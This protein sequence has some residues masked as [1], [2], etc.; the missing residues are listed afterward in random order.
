MKAKFIIYFASLAFLSLSITS[1]DTNDEEPASELDSYTLLAEEQIDGTSLMAKIYQENDS[2]IVGYNRFEIVLS[3]TGFKGDFT[4]AEIVFKPMMDMGTMQHACPIE[5]PVAGK[6]LPDVFGG[7]VVFVM[8]SGDMGSWMLTVEVTDNETDES[9]KLELP[10]KIT[11]PEESRMKSFTMGTTKYFVSLA[12][13]RDP[14]VGINDFEVTVH[15]KATMM[16]WPASGDFMITMEPE[17]PDMGHGSPNN[18]NP[19]HSAN[20]HYNGKVNFTM[21]GYWKINLELELDGQN[22]VLD[23]EVTF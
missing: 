2:L 7:A 17:M 6:N 1:C 11:L 10:V 16:D 19:V 13:P 5:N 18:V 14:K 21:D 4:S 12:E 23:F 20:G 3:K 22:Q 8:P 15:K 9:G